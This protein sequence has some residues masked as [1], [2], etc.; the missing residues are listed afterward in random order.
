VGARSTP[1]LSL[2]VALIIAGCQRAALTASGATVAAATSP[3]P[4]SCE[5]VAEV[6]GFA[7]GIIEGS[8]LGLD[9]K[10]LAAYALN[11]LRNA[12]A[13]EGADYVY[14]SEPTFSAPY[15]HVTQAEYAGYAYRCAPR[16]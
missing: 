5:R 16:R 6:R 1:A 4:P 9:E 3:P 14:R 8:V 12:A 13:A 10:G 2:A 7:G 15:G 11:D